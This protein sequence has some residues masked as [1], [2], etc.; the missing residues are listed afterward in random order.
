MG[1]IGRIKA[2]LARLLA[3]Q[4]ACFQQREIQAFFG[5]GFGDAQVFLVGRGQHGG[6]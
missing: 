6:K 1:R 5:G 3:M 4:T 2:A